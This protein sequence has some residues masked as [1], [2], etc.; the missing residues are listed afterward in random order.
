ME[1][2]DDSAV[3][4]TLQGLAGRIWPAGLVFD[5]CGL[6]DLV[7]LALVVGWNSPEGIGFQQLLMLVLLSSQ[8]MLSL[9]VYL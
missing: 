6:R 5:T 3:R 7:L 2:S 8:W 4:A 9:W 1:C